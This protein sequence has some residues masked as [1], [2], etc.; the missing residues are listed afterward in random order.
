[1]L[2]KISKTGRT[3]IDLVLNQYLSNTIL[4][5]ILSMINRKI[6]YLVQNMIIQ[7][8]IFNNITFHQDMTQTVL[9][10]YSF[11]EVLKERMFWPFDRRQ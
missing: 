3:N 9:K 5:V 1:M 7:H 4:R 6:I 10:R 8:I 11:L 2:N